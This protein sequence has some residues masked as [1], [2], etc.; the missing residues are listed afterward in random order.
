MARQVRRRAFF[1]SLAAAAAFVVV[2]TGLLWTYQAVLGEALIAAAVGDHRYCA[3]PTDGPLTLDAA[4]LQ[5]PAYRRLEILPET[6]AASTDAEIH[7]L[8]RHFCVYGGRQFAHLVLRYGDRR[9]SLVVSGTAEAAH[10]RPG[11][12]DVDGLHVVTFRSGALTL[13][14]VGD[15]PLTDLQTI[16]TL[17]DQH[18]QQS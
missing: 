16:A 1:R 7:V 12:A 3:L 17:I 9:V 10:A 4:V 5:W 15:L 13:F 2:C 11:T 6:I 8:D 18:L 14:V